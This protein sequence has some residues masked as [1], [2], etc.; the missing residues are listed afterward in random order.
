[1]VDRLKQEIPFILELEAREAKFAEGSGVAQSV[2]A[3]TGHDV[4]R[5]K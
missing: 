1:M 2:S 4:L 3:P 5:E